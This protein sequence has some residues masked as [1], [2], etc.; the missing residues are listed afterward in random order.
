M[1][2]QTWADNLPALQ[3]NQYEADGIFRQALGPRISYLPT[4]LR[5]HK[6]QRSATV[7]FL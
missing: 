7:L 6:T 3:L 2:A 1:L 5:F 4:V